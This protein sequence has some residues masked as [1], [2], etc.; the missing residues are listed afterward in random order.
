[1]LDFLFNFSKVLLGMGTN[2]LY[3]SFPGNYSTRD[4]NMEAVGSRCLPCKDDKTLKSELHYNGV[5]PPPALP[6]QLGSDKEELRQTILK[7]EVMFN[8]QVCSIS[9]LMLNSN[10]LVVNLI[11]CI[12]LGTLCALEMEFFHFCFSYYLWKHIHFFEWNH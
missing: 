10:T 8:D 4:L 3:E 9:T 11:C 6:R 12:D 1:M 2:L 5:L 7:Q